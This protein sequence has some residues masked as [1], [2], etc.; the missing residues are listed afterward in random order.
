MAARILTR[1]E[2]VH[3]II[4]HLGLMSAYALAF[5][6][7]LNPHWAGID[8]T[9]EW[10]AFIFGSA[11]MLGWCS[12]INVGVN[13]H[14]HTHRRIFRIEWLN[15]WFGRLWTVS[16]G[17]PAYW[18][19][20][21]HVIVH[22]E[23]LLHEN[24]WTLPKKKADGSWEGA[25]WYSI[26]H[27]P[28]RYVVDIVRDFREGRGG[29]E[30]GRRGLIEFLIF[31]PLWAIPFLIDWKMGLALW[32]LP[33]WIANVMVMAPGMYAQHADCE[34]ETEERPLAHSNTF[35]QRFFN[36][37]MFNIGYHIEHH[38]HPTVHW[39]ALPE[40]HDQIK[41]DL[42]ASDAHVVPYGYYRAGR[43]LCRRQFHAK[44]GE[45]WLQN[46]PEYPRSGDD[47][48]EPSENVDDLQ[49]AFTPPGVIGETRAHRET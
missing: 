7:F 40:L 39:S 10:A 33:A 11:L 36:L 30:V 16:G 8:K 48:E 38:T 45:I 6:I 37:T 13:F 41:D 2:D 5:T 3:C 15:R 35:L 44:S 19:E 14:N 25:Y 20:Y 28:W 17:W 42:I 46:H 1:R 4:F 31:L 43:L 22:H 47:P 21:S 49:S 26:S 23:D 18:W 27:W 9:W 12:G 32:L 29:A 34:K 24:D